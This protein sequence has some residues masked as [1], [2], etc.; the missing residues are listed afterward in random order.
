MNFDIYFDL[1]LLPLLNTLAE[2][3]NFRDKIHLLRYNSDGIYIFV[4]TFLP[5]ARRGRMKF[6][7]EASRANVRFQSS[8]RGSRNI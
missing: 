2:R 4:E 3:A 1:L 5:G 8:L 6:N 7:V